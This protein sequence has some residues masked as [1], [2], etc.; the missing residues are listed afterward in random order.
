MTQQPT[1]EAVSRSSLTRSLPGM[2]RQQP[3]THLHGQRLTHAKD[4]R[5]LALPGFLRSTVRGSR[6]SSP[7][8]RSV[9]FSEGSNRRSALAMPCAAACAWPDTPPPS[10]C[11]GRQVCQQCKIELHCES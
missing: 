1:K 5:A 4:L 9:A 6:F 3:H 8:A 2:P 11:A 10:T 7:A